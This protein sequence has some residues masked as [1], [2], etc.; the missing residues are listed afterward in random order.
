MNNNQHATSRLAFTVLFIL[1]SNTVIAR[2]DLNPGEA[3]SKLS[4]LS[5][6]DTTISSRQFVGE[7]TFTPPGTDDV[8]PL[9]AISRVVGVK[10]GMIQFFSPPL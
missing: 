4:N 10:P 6:T 2:S 9:P 7:N 8:L 5:M 3:C 1:L